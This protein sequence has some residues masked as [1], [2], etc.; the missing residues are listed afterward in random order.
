MYYYAL[1]LAVKYGALAEMFVCALVFLALRGHF[2]S[3]SCYTISKANM[4]H[5]CAEIPR[6]VHQFED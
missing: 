3:L 4:W 1:A 5:G 6:P 2:S